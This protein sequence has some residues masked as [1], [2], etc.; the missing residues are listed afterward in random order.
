MAYWRTRKRSKQEQCMSFR[1]AVLVM[2]ASV[3]VSFQAVAEP[4]PA[5]LE[6][7]TESNI[8]YYAD[9]RDEYQQERCKLDVYYPKGTKGYA[10]VVWFHGGGL[11]AGDRYFPGLLKQRGLAVVA[12]NYRLAPGA[13]TPSFIEDTAAAV[14]WVLRNIERYGGD[15]QKVFVAGHSAGAYLV[16]MIAMD[17]KW[18]AAEGLSHRQ[19]AGVVAVSGQ[20]STHP[21]IRKLSSEKGSRLRPI[22]DEY[23]PLAHVAKDLPPMC[24]VVGDRKLE[25]E[26]RVEENQFMEATLR[27]L[28]HGAVEFHEMSGLDHDTVEQGGLIL[29]PEFIKRTLQP[30]SP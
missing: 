9:A 22:I 7:A 30:K 27:N 10:T 15:P 11:T 6:Y 23:A 20:M 26:A 13:Q 1:R 19:L 18:L 21:T 29:L 8:S 2:L 24:I 12:V 16:T 14:A 3:V 25:I 5:K 4:K 28:G 17:P